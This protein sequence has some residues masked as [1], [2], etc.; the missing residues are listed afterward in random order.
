MNAMVRYV[1]IALFGVFTSLRV[2]T[3]GVAGSTP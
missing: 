2:L 1:T 3:V